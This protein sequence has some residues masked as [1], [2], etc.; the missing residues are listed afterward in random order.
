M[1][2]ANLPLFR[3]ALEWRRAGRAVAMATVVETWGSALDRAGSHLVTEEGGAFLGSVS[4]GCVEADVIGAAR[5]TMHTKAPCLLEFGVADETAQ[6]AGLSCGGRLK[7]FVEPI[8][9]A[10][11]AQ[12]ALLADECAARRAC[13]R[14]SDIDS[15]EHR[16]VRASEAANDPFAALL[17]AKLREGR[18]G[19]IEEGGRRLFFDVQMP[20]VRLLLIGATQIAQTLVGAAKLAGFEVTVIDP[21]PS[22]ATPERFPGTP[23]IASWPETVLPDL[24]LDGFTAVASLSH[25]PRM[26]DPALAAALRADCFYV[27]ALGSKITHAKRL[28]RLRAAGFCEADL[29]KIH[30]PIG[31]AIG[32]ANGPEI[33]IAILAEI[34]AVLRQKKPRFEAGQTG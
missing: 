9:A 1:S 14:I 17:A 15:G 25:D 28:E 11:A 32:A 26:E 13:V 16:L 8:G 22:F 24:K 18:G 4:G 3:K 19:L 33:A 2:A 6:R 27:G 23:V 34:I 20:S 7:V 29:A 31:L 12:L 30:A 21:R 10:E 5:E